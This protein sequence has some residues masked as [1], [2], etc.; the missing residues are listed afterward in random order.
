[1]RLKEARF[2]LGM[3]QYDLYFMTGIDQSRISYIERGYVSPQD[4]EKQKIENALER[5]ISWD[6]NK[7][8]SNQPSA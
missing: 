3:T 2:V 8:I 7:R 6:E 5:R 4:D 1:M